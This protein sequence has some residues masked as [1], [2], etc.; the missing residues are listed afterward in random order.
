VPVITAWQYE[1]G[2]DERTQVDLD[3][4][5]S[6]VDPDRCVVW[7]DCTSPSPDDLHRLRRQL[8]LSGVVVEALID[9]AQTTKLVR[10]GDYF[11]V[12]IHDCELGPDRRLQRREIDVVMGPGWLVTVR[13]PTGATHP[14]D[15]DMIAH[16]FQLQR[17][18]HSTTEEGFLLWAL[19][20]VVIDRYLEVV[21]TIDEQL[22][23]VEDAVFEVK[24]QS[25][26]QRGAFTLRRHLAEFRRAAAPMREVLFAITRKELPFVS[27]EALVHFRDLADRLLRVLDFVESQ[28]D[29][30]TGLLEADLAVISN[31]INQVMKKMTSWGAILIVATLIASIYG[32]NFANLPAL[33]WRFGYVFA[34]A[35]MAIVTLIL[36]RMFKRR[37]WL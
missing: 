15:V 34:L 21:D 19:F 33:H 1:S 8:G 9:P 16:H 37:D 20:D 28:R 13:H 14:L 2:V 35:L 30:L 29:L 36:Y 5:A 26:I 11:H 25:E 27:E 4:I 10:Y 22:D 18:E 7:V 17:S 24:P 12:A 32:M 31:R 23:T 6:A 3:H